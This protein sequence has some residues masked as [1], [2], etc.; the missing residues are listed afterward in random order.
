MGEH[1]RPTGPQ[2]AVHLVQVG[3]DVG[4]VLDGVEAHGRVDAAVLQGERVELGDVGAHAR[5]Q[6]QVVVERGAD[7]DGVHEA[8]TGGQ[9]GPGRAALPAGEV[10]RDGLRG[11]GGEVRDVLETTHAVQPT[12]TGTGSPA[13][14][15]GTGSSLLVLVRAQAVTRCAGRSKIP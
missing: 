3:A 13:G 7:V 11:D 9:Q 8:R 14:G 6:E 15:F 5:V 10:E 12:I 1:G 4:Q 2:H